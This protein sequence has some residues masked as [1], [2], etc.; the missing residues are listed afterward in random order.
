MPIV[1]LRKKSDTFEKKLQ[2]RNRA[3]ES[4]EEIANTYLKTSMPKSPQAATQ[5]APKAA[6][7]KKARVAAWIPWTVAAACL[8]FALYIFI[9]NSM[10]DIKIR[11]LN[12]SA[13]VSKTA[14]ADA[15]GFTG[16]EMFL[17]KGGQSAS[18]IVAKA[19]LQGDAFSASK[20]NS[21]E[22]ILSNAGGQGAASYRIDFKQPLDLSGKE[23]GYAAKS[24]EGARLVMVVTDTENRAYRVEDDAVTKVSKEWHAYTVNL[25]PV[26]GTI[27]LT[28]IATIRFEF[29]SSTVGNPAH[30]T[31]SLKDVYLTK[32]KRLKWL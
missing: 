28:S 14:A 12:K 15:P 29:G 22:I 32:S 24:A 11:L 31:I 21:D 23:I 3:L 27:D 7:K 25:K 16:S 4:F 6:P 30:T 26:K 8:S 2:Q 9:S 17:V 20:I 19:T 5:A 10:F 13:A 18:S 1:M